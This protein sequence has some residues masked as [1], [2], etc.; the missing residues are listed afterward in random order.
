MDQ[1]WFQ[2]GPRP[3]AH[4]RRQ[5]GS[6]PDRKHAHDVISLQGCFLLV[7][8]L[9]VGLFLNGNHVKQRRARSLKKCAHLAAFLSRTALAGRGGRSSSLGSHILPQPSDQDQ[10]AERRGG[11]SDSAH[12]S[13]LTH[14]GRPGKLLGAAAS[15]RRLG[16]KRSCRT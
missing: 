6:G 13:L 3:S 10:D 12:L 1:P 2:A 5:G 16:W 8:C 11:S 15:E 4:S 9:L 7:V 14:P